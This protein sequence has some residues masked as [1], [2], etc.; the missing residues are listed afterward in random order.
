MHTYSMCIT[1]TEICTFRLISVYCSPSKWVLYSFIFPVI[2]DSASPKSPHRDYN[3]RL[4]M[5]N[6]RGDLSQL[7][8][9]HFLLISFTY[10]TVIKGV[11]LS[12]LV[13][14]ERTGIYTGAFHKFPPAGLYHHKQTFGGSKVQG[15]ILDNISGV[16]LN[17]NNFWSLFIGW[18]QKGKKVRIS[19]YE[20]MNRRILRSTQEC[21]RQNESL[22]DLFSD[23]T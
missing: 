1:F 9:L 21:K 3:Q 18:R 6:F 17:P 14:E 5:F 7:L 23:H 4:V 10:V 15:A 19:S 2:I 16:V 8:S 11:H 12:F 22:F 20:I 13:A